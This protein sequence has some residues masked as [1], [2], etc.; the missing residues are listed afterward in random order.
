MTKKVETKKE[1]TKKE[2]SIIG[3]RVEQPFNLGG[4]VIEEYGDIAVIEYE[5]NGQ[6]K[7]FKMN[8]ADLKYI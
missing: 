8:K 7:I 3:R 1:E 2:Q 5:A 4:T 6:K